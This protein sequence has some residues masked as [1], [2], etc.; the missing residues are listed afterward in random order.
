MDFSDVG[1]NYGKLI[2]VIQIKD[3]RLIVNAVINLRVKNNSGNFLTSSATVCYR[4]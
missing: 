4:K 1:W 3:V 2:Y